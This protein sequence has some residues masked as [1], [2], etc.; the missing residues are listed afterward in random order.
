MKR[1]IHT[2]YLM[3][4]ILAP[5]IPAAGFQATFVM[6]SGEIFALPHDLEL[7]PDGRYLYVAD[8]G[9]DRVAVLEP[10][11]LNTVGFIGASELSA[12]HDVTFDQQGRLL[13][14]DS[15]N[16]RVVF[17]LVDAA[18]AER[19]AVIQGD[20]RRPEGVAAHSSGRV[21]VTGA[22]SDNV[23]AFENGLQ[24][25]AFG[26]LSRPHDVETDKQGNVLVV[27]SDNDRLLVMLP[28]LRLVKTLAGA[29]Y[30][31]NGPR[32]AV[33]DQK[34][35]V[36]VADKHAHRVKVIDPDGGLL[37][38]IGTGKPGKGPGLLNTPEG[39]AVRGRDVWISDTHNHRIVLYRVTQWARE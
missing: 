37:G 26:G 38:A 11:T 25:A 1:W 19:V 15:G 12:P 5:G 31:F 9:N 3:I 23:L 4:I 35:R 36:F 2:L 8:N 21:Y 27:D 16:N 6:A 33:F 10:D 32:Y 13:V 22:Y 20:F 30:H 7:S 39:V 17:Y 14:A 18:R 29:P 28:D 34:G 24:V